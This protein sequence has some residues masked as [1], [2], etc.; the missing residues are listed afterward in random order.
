MC[1]RMAESLLDVII[2]RLGVWDIPKKNIDPFGTSTRQCS[3]FSEFPPCR[4][5]RP[6]QDKRK[7]NYSSHVWK[8]PKAQ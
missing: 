1:L 2:R 8:H 6:N 4:T 7:M 3:E 5:Q